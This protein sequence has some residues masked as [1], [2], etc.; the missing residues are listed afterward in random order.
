MLCLDIQ[1]FCSVI[2][3]LGVIVPDVPKDHRPFI[4]SVVLVFGPFD[5]DENGSMIL[6]NARNNNTDTLLHPR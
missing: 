2:L 4:F 5:T 3:H 6:S 1:V